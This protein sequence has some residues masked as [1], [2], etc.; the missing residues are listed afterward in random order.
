MT[1][2][3]SVP[4]QLPGL[5]Y[6][7]PLGS[8]GY[9]DVFL[10]EQ[11][12]PRMPVAV[13]VLKPTGLTDR[14]RA[15][16]FAEADT[17]AALGDHPYIVQVFGSGTAPDGRPYLVMKYYPPPNL[18]QRARSERFAVA[19]VLRTGIQLASAIQTAHAA[20]IVHRDIKPANVLVSAYGAP[21]LTDFGVAGRGAADI[22]AAPGGSLGPEQVGVSVP[23]TAPEV[24]Y[25]QSDGDVRSDVYSLG[26]T[27][28]H[29]L[30]GRS[31]FEVPGGDNA[32]YALMP[33]IRTMPVPTTGRPDVPAV[34]ERLLAQAMA[35]DPA[36]RPA[37]ALELA[38]GLQGVEAALHLPATQILVL[39]PP[40][41]PAA[42]SLP[43]GT[44]F[45]DR[46][47]VKGVQRV[48]AQPPVTPA[49]G[50][51]MPPTPAAATGL[52][53]TTGPTTTGPTTTGPMSIGRA[54]NGGPSR[55][56][57]PA[58]APP[59]STVATPTS[60]PGEYPAA[61]NSS[62]APW[63]GHPESP[64]A[65]QAP[66]GDL[67]APAARAMRWS[68]VAVL[69]S[70]AALALAAVTL[71]VRRD[72]APTPS[73]PVT[74]A[75]STDSNA[76]DGGVFVAPTVTA[77]AIPGGVRF[78]WTYQNPLE[79][80]TFQIRVGAT[81]LDAPTAVPTIARAPRHDVTAAAGSR[82]CAVVAVVRSG[83]ISP[84]SMAVCAAAG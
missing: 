20:H 68:V 33:R 48:Q 46:T 34:L 57:R 71:I 65:E 21:G 2:E 47:H 44:A 59:A 60:T 15:E 40:R 5:T 24:V 66:A 45:D 79:R 17:M 77:T 41:S 56:A 54:T 9:A 7:Q 14:V 42:T 28:W 1:D 10:Y 27:L 11:H 22:V 51:G 55:P 74:V 52:P 67:P 3:R 26:A 50:T 13:K 19:D 84:P 53:T 49:A 31:P 64:A 38:R 12:S 73:A 43:S 23:W 16:F 58:P 4:P 18:A 75:P 32:A 35:K 30:A 8:G 78:A 70:C 83:Q 25:A 62:S 6:V 80:D 76:L 82:I 72:P 29:M 61:A 69:A 81:E 63:P 36:H 37:S 39:D